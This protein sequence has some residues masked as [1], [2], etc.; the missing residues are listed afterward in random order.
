MASQ[1][2]FEPTPHPIIETMA[3]PRISFSGDFSDGANSVLGEYDPERAK[4]HVTESERAS[5]ADF[6]FFSGHSS[7]TML[8]ADEL[9]SE[10]RIIP[11][12]RAQQME[13]LDKIDL[14]PKEEVKRNEEGPGLSWFADEDPSPRLPT[15]TVLWKE[16][17]RLK[18]QRSPS[19]SSV[20]DL[21]SKDDE[22]GDDGGS[23]KR[24]KHMMRTKKGLERT[25]SGSIRMRPVVHVPVCTQG[26]NNAM[27]L[28][29]A[30]KKD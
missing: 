21:C 28:L 10:G 23:C 3:I 24:E 9:F 2:R 13:K 25:R 6:E 8:T 14:K 20:I 27:P 16:L 29:F 7:M 18:K 12:H 11:F 30:L 19:S 22:R 15:C 5:E 17:L 4:T 1:E 26:K